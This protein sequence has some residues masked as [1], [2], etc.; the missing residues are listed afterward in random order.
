MSAE[1]TPIHNDDLDCWMVGFGLTPVSASRAL[2]VEFPDVRQWMAWNMEPE[3]AAKA[4]KAFVGEGMNNSGKIGSWSWE[5]VPCKY[6]NVAFWSSMLKKRN[7]GPCW[8]G[9]IKVTGAAGESFLLFSYLRADMSIGREYLVSTGDLDLLRRFADDVLRRFRPRYHRNTV[10]VNV[11]NQARDFHLKVN[12][13][14]DVYLPDQ[15]RD[16]IMSQVD[17][18]FGG[19][20]LY[21]KLGIPHKR[22][23]LFT[24]LPGTGKT[25]L[26]RNIIR[27]VHRKYRAPSSYLSINRRTDADDLRSLFNEASESRPALLVLEDVESLCEETHL[28]RSEVLAELDGIQQRSGML[29][30][31]TAND[32]GRIDPALVHRPS[33]FDRVWTFPLPDRDLRYRYI[34]EQFKEIDARL[35]ARVAAETNDWTFAYIKELRNTAGILAIRDGRENMTPADLTGALDLLQEQF[36]AGRSN[37]KEMKKTNRKVGFDIGNLKHDEFDDIFE[38]VA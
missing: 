16:D 2:A 20:K 15:L 14:E 21:R 33:R 13:E 27:H 30:I 31:A 6:G 22:G 23:F 4:L 26:I 8:I 12:E 36:K 24:G 28:T 1:I 35:A 9:M 17:G 29:L 19:K 3:P 38:S 11:V 10:T 18:F 5:R 25:M 37:H 7:I 34:S 32:P